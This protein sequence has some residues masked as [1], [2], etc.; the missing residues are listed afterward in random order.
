[1]RIDEEGARSICLKFMREHD[2]DEVK[3]I[4][5]S[6]T[7]LH[8]LLI[9]NNRNQN[10]VLYDNYLSLLDVLKKLIIEDLEQNE[11]Y[12]NSF[13]LSLEDMDNLNLSEYIQIDKDLAKVADQIRTFSV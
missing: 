10:I 9:H 2:W 12:S 4:C 5:H 13:Y 3:Y 1:M 6:R 8:P 7:G 11:G